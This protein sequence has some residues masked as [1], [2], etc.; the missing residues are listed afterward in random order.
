LISLVKTAFWAI[1]ISCT[2]TGNQTTKL[3]I[4]ALNNTFPFKCELFKRHEVLTEVREWAS[5]RVIMPHNLA[6]DKHHFKGTYP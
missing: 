2:I 5:F 6:G 4:K 1:G 3:H